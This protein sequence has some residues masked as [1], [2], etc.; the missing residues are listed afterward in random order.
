MTTIKTL[1]LS[2]VIENT[3][4]DPTLVRAL[5]RWHGG[6]SEFKESASDISNYGANNG[7]SFI[8]YTDSTKFF[9]AHAPAIKEW[10]TY[11][12]EEIYDMGIGQ[13]L[14]QWKGCSDYSQDEINQ[15]IY[16]GKGDA[17][18]SVF[19]NCLWAIVEELATNICDLID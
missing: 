1:K 5:V 6:W 11:T 16:T 3:N 4:I 17:V 14:N 2:E 10:L 19:C 13:M 15:A 12:A 18:D 7:N 8:Y 9:R